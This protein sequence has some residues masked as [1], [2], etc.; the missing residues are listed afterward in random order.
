M[1]RSFSLIILAFA[2]PFLAAFWPV[3]FGGGQFGYR[4]AAH[5]YY[6]LHKRIAEQWKVEQPPLWDSGE[7]GGMTLIG[8]PTAAVLYP[9]K[10]VFAVLSYPSAAR[11]YILIHVTI[12]F[13]ALWFMLRRFG[14]SPAGSAIGAL[15]YSFGG[16]V[17]FQYCNAIYLVG[18]AWLPLGVL[19]AEGWLRRGSRR[20]LAGLA[21]VISLQ[22]LGGDIQAAYLLGAFVVG[23]DLVGLT[24]Q[25]GWWPSR[26]TLGIGILAW[27][28][29][30]LGL[31]AWLPS[32]RFGGLPDF[33]RPWV[34][35]MVKL[36]VIALP[37][38]LIV[39]RDHRLGQL[40]AGRYGGLA[41]A[42]IVGASIA[43][44]QL[45][46]VAE[47]AAQS[48]RMA[49]DNRMD[50]YGF[51]VE[52]YRL[53]EAVWPGFFGIEYPENRLWMLAIP[54]LGAHALWTASLY[55]GGLAVILAIA[56]LMASAKNSPAWRRPMAAILVAA[57]ALSFGRFGSPLWWARYFPSFATWL[58]PHGP[59]GSFFLRSEDG[60]VRDAFGSPYW[61]MTVVAPGFDGF[62]FPP[63][64]FVFASL[65][66]SALAG[67][68]WDR[69]SAGTDRTAPRIAKALLIAGVIG[70][71][72]SVLSGSVLVGWWTRSRMV[73]S[74]AGPIDA[75]GALW[76]LRRSLVH[77]VAIAAMSL[78]VLV[79]ASRGRR[80]AGP[81]A[82]LL[83]A[84][85]L[86][87]ANS[88]I[89]WTVPQTEF[90]REPRGARAIR[91]SEAR[92][93]SPGPF[94]IARLPEW[95][96]ITW[97]RTR[98]PDR[99]R[100]VVAWERDTLQS[101]HGTNYGLSYTL[102]PGVLEPEA[103]LDLFQPWTVSLDPPVALMLGLKPGQPVRYFPRRAFDLWGARYFVLP[104]VPDDWL[105]PNRAIAAFLLNTESILPEGGASAHWREFE[106]WQLLRNP[107]AWPRSW[108]V[109]DVRV[110]P[111]MEPGSDDSRSLKRSLLHQADPFWTIAD[112]EVEDPR[113]TA[114]IEAESPKLLGL[115][116]DTKPPT[117]AETARIV[118]ERP[119]RL[120]V[121][122]T[123]A[124][125]GLLIVADT[126]APG[127][128][129]TIDDNPATIW[130]TNR[131]MR[132]VVVPKGT[133]H[134]TFAYHPNSFRL[135]LIASGLGFVGL[136]VLM[137]PRRRG[138]ALAG[139]PAIFSLERGSGDS[140][141]PS[142]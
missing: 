38:V 26:R 10:L 117:P 125:D 132:G 66:A 140:G 27:V 1:R 44:A 78:F 67:L 105:D 115:P 61:L 138:V 86:A 11:A 41:V 101:G 45:L 109:H 2:I 50:I 18:A 124:R 83:L 95:H 116:E 118:V 62:R 47:L 5:Y 3:L 100:E 126:F 113:R 106:D 42:A 22:C 131:A 20:S 56:G 15:S 108:V 139:Q 69:V 71:F 46:P 55:S 43:G 49:D 64:L 82:V 37:I 63:K 21:A 141:S 72:L 137:L 68:G 102:T 36:V 112:R 99:L 93:P 104:V 114:W 96:P 12:A 30:V 142:P 65:G 24:G 136:I 28:A 6:P 111:L 32:W 120:E 85:D 17:L 9:G 16:P 89:V 29:I 4:D 103:Y 7:N 79:S 8:N 127:W 51:S 92:S 90:D 73:P 135:G 75:A 77:G 80:W 119:G 128:T 23:A 107:S 59:S 57:I 133:H 74:I 76:E 53:A 54:P 58:G 40:L 25:R 123:L 31:A 129:A 19:A 121:D 52:P 110:R 88:R 87:V 33:V 130:R 98:S 81:A 14:V 39:R 34:D 70:L 134:I 13:G 60:F 122:A 84:V 35:R 91:E 97:I 94:R 48:Y